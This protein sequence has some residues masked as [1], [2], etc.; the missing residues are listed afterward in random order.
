MA[1]H[2]EITLNEATKNFFT[3]IMGKDH[4]L[5]DYGYFDD[6]CLECNGTGQEEYFDFDDDYLCPIK[7]CLELG[8]LQY[9]NS[10]CQACNQTGSFLKSLH[11]ETRRSAPKSNFGILLNH[12][13]MR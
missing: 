8:T 10:P 12:T 11:V 9:K 1:R 6:C 3:E 2:R 7:M 13:L 5:T 4:H